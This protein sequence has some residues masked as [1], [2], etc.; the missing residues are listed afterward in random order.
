MKNYLKLILCIGLI[1]FY[2]CNDD[3]QIT[4]VIP[5]A[6]V[7]DDP[8]PEEA[9]VTLA[10]HSETPAFLIPQPG[11]ENLQ[12]FSL[13]GSNDV[14]EQTPDFIF[15]GSADGAGLLANDDGTFHC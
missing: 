2:A 13:F 9:V 1:S 3:D 14:L 12:T 10:N 8:E 15:G 7:P 5:D 6:E 11:F 4:F